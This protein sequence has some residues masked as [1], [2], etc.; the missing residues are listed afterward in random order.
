[1]VGGARSNYYLE[2]SISGAVVVGLTALTATVFAAAVIWQA[3][4]RKPSAFP[5]RLRSQRFDASENSRFCIPRLNEHQCK[6][7]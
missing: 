6:S 4:H 3:V 7:G 1:M 2:T 5:N